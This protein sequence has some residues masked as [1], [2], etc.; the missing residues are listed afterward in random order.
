MIFL[1]TIYLIKF[2]I[3]K[4]NTI[5]LSVLRYSVTT[6]DIG[7][8]YFLVWIEARLFLLKGNHNFCYFIVKFKSTNKFYLGFLS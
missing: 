7:M 2:L 3:K 4:N 8:K 1:I 5:L 6:N